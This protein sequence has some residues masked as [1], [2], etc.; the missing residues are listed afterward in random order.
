MN[1]TAICRLVVVVAVCLCV[2]SAQ[3]VEV[4]NLLQNP[5]FELGKQGWSTWVEDANA[6][7]LA[8]PDTNEKVKGK[9]SLLIDIFAAGGGKR[10]EL[11]Q[12]PLNLKG[13]WAL[14][15]AI[16]LKGDK[17]RNAKIICNHRADPWTSYGSKDIVIQQDWQEFWTAVQVPADDAIAGIYLELRDTKG[18]V[19][20]DAVRLFQGDY[21]ADDTIGQKPRAVEP[22]SKL[23]TTWADAKR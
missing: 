6:G 9:Q 12:N 16:W 17:V 19:W 13:G 14:T 1:P 21:V 7:A 11:H 8:E 18:K 5:E 23:A 10:V 3:A 2:S 22:S 15:Y 4:A 20:V